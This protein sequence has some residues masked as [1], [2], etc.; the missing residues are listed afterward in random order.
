MRMLGSVSAKVIEASRL[1]GSTGTVIAY[2]LAGV[3]T[4]AALFRTA[5]SLRS[6]LDWALVEPSRRVGDKPRPV[7]DAQLLDVGVLP[8]ARAGVVHV[9]DGV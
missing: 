8:V 1:V 5:K 7:R 9:N 4:G 3:A 6:S 2:T